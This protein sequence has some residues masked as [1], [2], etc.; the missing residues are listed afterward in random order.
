[1]KSVFAGLLVGTLA[2]GIA[3]TSI[4]AQNPS[5]SATPSVDFVR[6]VQPIFRE[7]CYGC[8]GPQQQMNGFR[9]D[10]RRDAMRGGVIPA[11]GPGNSGGSRLYQRLVSGQFGMQMPP[12]GALPTNEIA[13]IK[14]WIDQ[15]AIW[16]DEAAGEADIAPLD[17][18]A[19]RI[20]TL[21]RS[22]DTRAVRRELRR[23]PKLANARAI[24]GATPLMFASFYS[25]VALVREMLERGADPNVR[26]DAG[27]T[28]LMWAVGD[29]DKTRALLDRGVDLNVRSTD[30]RT[31][32][33]IAA[34]TQGATPIVK[35]LLERGADVNVVGP[36]L[37][38]P[39]TA[40]TEAA[41]AGNLDAFK[42]LVAAGA[43]LTAGPAAL[44][45][46]LRA[47]CMECAGVLMKAYPEPLISGTLIN[48]GPPTGPA[49]GTPVFLEQ[50]ARIDARDPNGRSLL[51]LAAASEAMPVDS[52][53]ALLARNVDVNER[54]ATGDTALKLARRHGDTP[55]VKLLLD[56][57]AQDEPTPTPPAPSPA[58]SAQHALERAMPLLQ[59]SD[60]T[61]VK[62]SGCVSCHNNS[63][64]ALALVSARKLGVRVDDSIAREQGKRIGAYMET[65]RERG[66]QGVSI[67]GE[68]DTV[69]YL[70]VGLG[71][72]RHPADFATDAH[73]WLL[74][75]SQAADGRW[76]IFAHR[77]P[78]ESSDVQVTALSMRALQ[79]YAP[80]TRKAEFD[81]AIASAAVW[82]RNATARTTEERAFQL[83]G[84]KWSDTSRTQIEQLG[85]ALVAEQRPD[86]GW[87]QLPTMGSDA[88]ATGQAL[89][90]L[91]ESGAL[92]PGSPAFRRGV[93]FL[94]KTQLA[95]GS[96]Y[97]RTRA[98]PIQPLFDADFP[99]GPDAFI[100]A[101][102]TNWATMALGF[103]G[104]GST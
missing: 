41:M 86:G 57:G 48:S 58:R 61:F 30:G 18:D 17:R 94:L 39:T 62:K 67:P 59:R 4:N 20:A 92:S 66:V 78:I 71:T 97:V 77:P 96:W 49:L 99:H 80:A 31:A 89:Y 43:S 55:I 82:L 36:A 90:A 101:A 38:G 9:L 93:D 10:R 65:W 34:G 37:Y 35:L 51:M 40:L 50:G 25:D 22:G 95:D 85:R 87:S 88:Y 68:A 23:N 84:L 83:L 11:I 13:T 44:G 102:A 75:R 47:G 28:A 53:K 16:P 72:A 1:M 32:L 14:A 73:A 19:V 12:T 76:R 7:K 63:L 21:I 70:L 52:V 56:A 42:L 103:A 5:S 79:M 6:D 15:G 64:T 104:R 98:I 8:H 54:T 91:A 27:A 3:V 26:N 74:K 69:S 29:L 46:A 45:L 60:V 2:L 81:E 33:M 100:S 24:G